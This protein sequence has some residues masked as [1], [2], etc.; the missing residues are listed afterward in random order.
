MSLSHRSALPSAHPFRRAHL[1]TRLSSTPETWAWQSNQYSLDRSMLMRKLSLIRPYSADPPTASDQRRFLLSSQL[2]PFV[3]Q[4]VGP[5]RSACID[6][7]G[8]CWSLASGV[9]SGLHKF[10]PSSQHARAITTV[11][12]LRCLYA[13]CSSPASSTDHEV[14]P[15]RPTLPSACI[16]TS[17]GS[18]FPSTE[19]GRATNGL[20]RRQGCARPT[21]MLVQLTGRTRRAG[22]G[23]GCTNWPS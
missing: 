6:L 20:R 15:P 21:W 18:S 7:H 3:S 1:S 22:R 13:S 9:S 8:I 14:P 23:S 4:H 19:L 5:S 17:L 16:A 12:L 11:R 10:S 2:A